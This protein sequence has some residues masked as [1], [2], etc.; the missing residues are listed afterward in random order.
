MGPRRVLA[1]TIVCGIAF[2][3]SGRA[4]VTGLPVLNSGITSGLTLGGEVGWP[5][6]DYGKGTSFG[7][8]AAVGLGP[9]GVS[10]VVSR[11]SPNGA[12][13]H[14]GVGG[15]LNLK[16]FGG[17]LIPLSVTLQGGGEY[18][19]AQG[20]KVLHVPVGLGI[21]LK[22]PNP[23]LAIKPWIA[24]RFDL[25]RVSPTSGSSSTTKK[26]GI[27]GGLE[28]SLLGGF[29]FGAAYDRTFRGSGVNPSI[30]SVG[31]NYTLKIPGL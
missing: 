25:V 16:V 19:S 10:G 8:R 20:G 30:F 27:S 4:Q 21:A 5:N 1:L 18:A 29:G 26:F 2:T 22:I 15:Y 17:P 7:G 3:A 13:S 24:P 28:F 11:W 14:T 6:A 9:L 31:V 23:A 12:S